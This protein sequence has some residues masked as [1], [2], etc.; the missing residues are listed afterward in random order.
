[1][2][3]AAVLAEA[4]R[5]LDLKGGVRW[6]ALDVARLETLTAERAPHAPAVDLREPWPA[7]WVDVTTTS[8]IGPPPKRRTSSDARS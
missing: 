2:W 1:V 8:A 3:A 6:M 5:V 7:R 4:S